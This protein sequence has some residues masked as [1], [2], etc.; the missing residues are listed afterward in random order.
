MRYYLESKVEEKAQTS[1]FKSLIKNK[2]MYSCLLCVPHECL[3]PQNFLNTNW[4]YLLH[5]NHEKQFLHIQAKECQ[6]EYKGTNRE[7]LTASN[8]NTAKAL[9]SSGGSLNSW[10]YSSLLNAAGDWNLKA[11][12]LAINARSFKFNKNKIHI[13]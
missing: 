2:Q 13:I 5:I 6:K 3:R 4:L 9:T 8:Y 1:L 7:L 12:Q 11:S 10:R